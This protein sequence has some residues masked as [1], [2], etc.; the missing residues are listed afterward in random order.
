MIAKGELLIQLPFLTKR[1]APQPQGTVLNLHVSFCNTD[2][3]TKLVTIRRYAS[4]LRAYPPRS[5]NTPFPMCV[6]VSLNALISDSAH[7]ELT[8]DER[9]DYYVCRVDE[10]LKA[11]DS[12]AF[13]RFSPKKGL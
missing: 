9:S 2:A 4:E 3:A 6:R 1:E 5:G 13:I 7:K 10:Y 8:T 12:I 11:L